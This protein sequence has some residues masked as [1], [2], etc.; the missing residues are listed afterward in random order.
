LRRNSDTAAI[1]GHRTFARKLISVKA[2]AAGSGANPLEGVQSFVMRI[3][4]RHALAAISTG[5]AAAGALLWQRRRA[6]EKRTMFV[7]Q[8]QPNASYVALDVAT[9]RTHELPFGADG[10]QWIVSQAFADGRSLL[11]WSCPWE[12]LTNKS[13]FSTDYARTPTRLFVFDC[14]T[15]QLRPLGP[16]PSEHIEPFCI[17]PDES[18]LLVNCVHADMTSGIFGFDWNLK[19]RYAFKDSAMGEHYC[20]QWNPQKTRLAFHVAGPAPRR[21][22]ICTSDAR[23]DDT[24]TLC[25]QYERGVFGPQWSPDG[26][27][28]SC[29]ASWWA[30]DD[31][32]GSDVYLI[33]VASRRCRMLDVTHWAVA[34]SGPLSSPTFGTNLP[35]WTPDG[36][37]L[38]CRMRPDE[39]HSPFSINRNKLVDDHN[40]SSFHSGAGI[41]GTEIVRLATNGQRTVLVPFSEHGWLAHANMTGVGQLVYRQWNEKDPERLRWVVGGS[42]IVNPHRVAGIR[43]LR[44]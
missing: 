12:V 6:R 43:E 10:Q 3:S 9:G 4:R 18:G 1:S 31:H 15:Q 27:K 35:S 37:L 21:Y 11:V 24:V 44:L 34:R 29:I 5:A 13:G 26:S 14:G 28:I 30:A 40:N 7:F 2:F 41:G 32:E 42:E 20:F 8:P 19:T 17:L 39:A 36:D 16:P 38:V 23:G 33:D 25:N 22:W